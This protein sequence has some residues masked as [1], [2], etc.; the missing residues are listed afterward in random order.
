MMITIRCRRTHTG[1]GSN[2][3]VTGVCVGRV[4][5]IIT[6]KRT[7]YIVKDVRGREHIGELIEATPQQTG[8]AACYEYAKNLAQSRKAQK[9]GHSNNEKRQT[10]APVQRYHEPRRVRFLPPQ[11]HNGGRGARASASEYSRWRECAARWVSRDER[12]A[13]AGESL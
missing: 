1:Y 10:E 2:Y 7:Y 13:T 5:Y 8:F 11:Y 9:N 6:G 3:T 4:C 12:P